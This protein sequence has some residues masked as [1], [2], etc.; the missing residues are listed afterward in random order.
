MV[1]A[2]ATDLRK[3]KLEAV[4]EVGGLIKDLLNVIKKFRQWAEPELVM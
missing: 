3:P 4:F 1:A 2:L